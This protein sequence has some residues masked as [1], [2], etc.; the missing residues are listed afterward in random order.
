MHD[1]NKLYL[2]QI[3]RNS[4]IYGKLS[5][6]SMYLIVIKIDGMY[7]YCVTEKGSR[8]HLSVTTPLLE[9]EDG[10]IIQNGN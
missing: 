3:P 10:Y 8:A 2:H 4:K 7:S 9:Y 1:H 6:G 5:D